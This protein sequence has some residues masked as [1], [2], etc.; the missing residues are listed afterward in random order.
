MMRGMD[1]EMF[2]LD[3]GDFTIEGRTRAGHETFLRIRELGIGLDIG[4]GPDLMLS[5][6]HLF[7]THAHLDHAAGIPFYAG[8]RHLQ[9]AGGGRVYVPAE[10]A[11]DFRELM[12]IHSRLEGTPYDVE[13]IGLA[14]GDEV[15]ISR[16]LR[17]RAHDATH[18]VPARAYEILE[19]RHHLKKELEGL[20]G[21]ALA[22]LR[23]RGESVEETFHK[24]ILFY[25]GD[26]DRGLLE[27]NEAIYG[28]RVLM[29]ECSF[30][31]PEHRERAVTYRHIHFDDIAEFAGRFE[32]ELIVLTHFSRRYSH[33][34][35]VNAL[36]ARCP[37]RLRDRIRLAFPEPWQRL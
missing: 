30:I 19:R 16:T 17:G 31:A 33:E 27:R 35:I 21:R 2:S 25:T 13:I 1:R 14:P 7:V 22:E 32:N 37:A 34:E 11:A 28:A 8:Q 3:A 4:R 9:K 12:S 18:R 20:D 6:R 10:T 23:A 26:T 36:R 15:E 29:M 24:S 5:L